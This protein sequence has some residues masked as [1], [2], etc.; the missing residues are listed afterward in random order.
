MSGILKRMKFSAENSSCSLKKWV[1]CRVIG[2]H[3]NKIKKHDL[4]CNARIAS[5]FDFMEFQKTS[6]CKYCLGSLH[7]INT[8]EAYASKSHAFYQNDHPYKKPATL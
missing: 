4:T 5:Y 6:Q 8:N 1:F 3:E 2:Q 7:I